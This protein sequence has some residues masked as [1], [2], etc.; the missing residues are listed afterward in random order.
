ME[1]DDVDVDDWYTEENIRRHNRDIDDIQ[2][3]HMCHIALYMRNRIVYLCLSGQSRRQICPVAGHRA[4]IRGNSYDIHQW[5]ELIDRMCGLTPKSPLSKHS[6][7]SDTIAT[8]NK[9]R[10]RVSSNSNS[11]NQVCCT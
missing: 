8:Q 11:T 6:L 4:L 5:D 3:A 9:K 7:S 2:G 1:V 10:K